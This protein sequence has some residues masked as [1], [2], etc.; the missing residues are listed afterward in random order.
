MSVTIYYLYPLFLVLE[1]ILSLDPRIQRSLLD[2][3]IRNGSLD[4]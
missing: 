1:C 4:L 3:G 2:L